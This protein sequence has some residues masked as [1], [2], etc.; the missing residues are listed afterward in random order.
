MIGLGAKSILL[1]SII[2][3]YCIARIEEA[4]IYL[5]NRGMADVPGANGIPPI[6]LRPMIHRH[7]AL[8]LHHIFILGFLLLLS[9]SLQAKSAVARLPFLDSELLVPKR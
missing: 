1:Y 6:S 2:F 5:A 9:T 8:M 4:S 3:Y 7:C